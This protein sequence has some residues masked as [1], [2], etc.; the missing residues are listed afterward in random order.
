[1]IFF[2]Y[3]NLMGGGGQKSPLM[4]VAQSFG[5]IFHIRPE[6][7]GN[8]NTNAVE[9]LHTSYDQLK[10]LTITTNILP[11][12]RVAYDCSRKCCEY[13]F[14]TNFRSMFL[15]FTRPRECLRTPQLSL[16]AGQKNCRMFQ[17]ERS[18]LHYP[19]YATL[20]H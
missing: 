14:L 4:H 20:C 1:M 17:A 3:F 10:R 11:S 8:V 2:L 15:I 12:I 7:C 13:A 5:L 9:S 16:N 19:H 18:I 6:F